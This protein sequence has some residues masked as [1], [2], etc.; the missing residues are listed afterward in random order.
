VDELQG[1]N[2]DFFLN[3]LQNVT[4]L[5]PFM[6]CAGN[7]EQAF[8]FSHLA[9]KFNNWNYVHDPKG[10][11]DQNWWYSVRALHFISFGFSPTLI[12]VPSPVLVI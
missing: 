4:A 2:G 7:H 1:M 8:N 5:V 3:D 11:P 12:Q 10:K 6:G 9:N